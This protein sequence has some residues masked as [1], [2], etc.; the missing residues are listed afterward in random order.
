[1]RRFLLVSILLGLFF[2]FPSSSFAQIDETYNSTSKSTVYKSDNPVDDFIKSVISL[3]SAN[4]VDES[5]K[6]LNR[7]SL[8][9]VEIKTITN[10]QQGNSTSPDDEHLVG[11]TEE[12][13]LGAGR[14][15]PA[16]LSDASTNL[17]Q[18]LG[19]HIANIFKKGDDEALKYAGSK[20]QMGVIDSY[21]YSKHINSNTRANN[22]EDTR[23]LGIS[24]MSGGNALGQAL[25]LLQ[26]ADL[27]FGF[28][29]VTVE[30]QNTSK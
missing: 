15:V 24:E 23:V 7:A 30:L 26:C 6:K 12:Y 16:T 22:D 27:P 5:L 2:P 4:K 1:M 14:Q 11:A 18:S 3:I 17:F 8:P 9:P 29:Q 21:L 13:T 20:L 19:K 28:C 25:P 10:Q